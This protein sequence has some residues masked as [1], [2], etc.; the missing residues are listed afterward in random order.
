MTAVDVDRNLLFGLLAL[1]NGLIDQD[2]LLDAIRSWIRDKGRPIADY[3]AE[4]RSIDDE[5]RDLIERLVTLNLARPDGKVERSMV[6]ILA[7]RF[8]RESLAGIGDPDLDDSLARFG[9]GSTLDYCD[10]DPDRAA[11][12]SVGS[13]TSDGQRFRILRPHAHGGL[14]AV[15]VAVDTELNR[16]VAL[17]QILDRYADDPDSRRRFLLEAEVTGGLEHPGIVPV[18]GLGTDDFGRPYYAMRFIEGDSLKEAIHRFHDDAASTKDPGR[19][20]LGLRQL[21]RRF[22]DVCNTIEYAHSR[23]VLHRDIKPANIIVGRYGETLVVNWGL[24]KPMDQFDSGT[25]ASER[26][27]IPSPDREC[28]ATLPG[29]ALGT[30]A[31]MSPEQAEGRPD[32]VGPRSDVYGLGATLYA[33]LTG[34][35]PFDGPDPKVILARVSAGD[36]S[37]PRQDDPAVPVALEAICLKAMAL[38]PEGRYASPRELGEDIERWLADEPV[39]AYPE[40]PSARAMRWVRRRKQWVAAAAAMLVLTVLGLAIHNRQITREKARTAD[41][42]AMTRESLRELLTVAGENLAF[43]PHTETLREQL[44]RLVLDRYRRLGDS[45]PTDPGVRF[46]TAKVLRVIGGIDRITGQFARAQES[47]DKAIGSLTALCEEDPGHPEYRRRLAETFLDRGELNHMNGRT[48]DAENDLRAAIGH[49]D[50]LVSRSISASSRRVKPSALIN[51]SEILVLRARPAE[52][53]TAADQAVE[54]LRPLAAAAN[55]DSTTVDRW[56]LSLALTARG[57]ASWEV[58]ARDRADHDFDEASQVAGSVPRD[59]D[60]YD[61][62]QFQLACIANRRGELASKDASS[63]AESERSYEEASRILARL[64]KDH[65]QIPHYREEMAGTLCGLAA[66]RLA[67]GRIAEAEGDCKAALGHLAWLIGEQT[68]QGAPE[69]PEYLSLLGRILA[70][71]SRIHQLQGRSMEARKS[72]DDAVEKLS[73]AVQLDPA[74]AADRALLERIQ[75]DPARWED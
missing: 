72:Q 5:R 57:V 19:R 56:L 61:D 26:T 52:A 13:A 69:N 50:Q 58:G 66:V 27:P 18:Y 51:L 35:P 73:R 17:K 15:F 20:S 25:D 3:L 74:R 33:I 38:D 71:Q 7:S 65:E 43:V 40:P 48:L 46:E 45:F 29:Y 49:A 28:A 53:R 2:Q 22:N 75:G 30:P 37:R 62:A 6:S 55:P 54:L 11:G 34:K 10:G 44:A 68:R 67:A 23:G 41:Q 21:L 39:R 32:R 47:Y 64:I 63:L 42:L 24:V 31:Y 59:D 16:K 70:R 8:A 9:L 36:F 60:V 14:G 1:Q 12:S 4:L